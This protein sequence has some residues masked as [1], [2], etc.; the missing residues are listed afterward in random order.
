MARCTAV[1]ARFALFAQLALA[2]PTSATMAAPTA[3]ADAPVSEVSAT[4]GTVQ[5]P[6]ESS[7]S[8]TLEQLTDFSDPTAWWHSTVELVSHKGI[9]LAINLLSAIVIFVV[10]R[11]VAKILTRIISRI[12]V[13]A[14]V[15]ETLV[16][17]STNLSYAAMLA[18][19]VLSS[20]NR[21]GIDT[22]SFT[23]VV[24]AAGLAI[25]FALQ[26]SLSNFAAG[27]LLIVFKPFKVGDHVL[28][29]GST[30]TVE[31]IQIFNTLIRADNNAQIIVPNSAITGGTITNYSA[32]RV[33][34]VDITFRCSYDNDL[35][36][37]KRFLVETL[38]DDDRILQL[39]PPVVAIDQL[40]DNGVSFI[41][42][43][44]VRTEYFQAVRTDLLEAIKLGFQAQGFRMAGQAA[45][46]AAPPAAGSPPSAAAA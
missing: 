18:F 30:G 36:A 35:R 40:A 21:I 34:R 27:V 6:A 44:W 22:T 1:F 14:K 31:E 23:A 29:G 41:V 38:Q 39:P 15:D 5:R 43:P 2:W 3:N 17:F 42:Q 8:Q 28:A 26:G 37:L 9:E 13:K 11:W 32:E 12:A 46:P 10:G 20:L 7:L 24:A 19:V 25:G 16:K 33:R 4:D 45:K